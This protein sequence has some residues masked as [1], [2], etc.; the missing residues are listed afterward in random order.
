MRRAL[1]A[2]VLAGAAAVAQ[3]APPAAS[4]VM[5]A[6]GTV[7]RGWDVLDD[8]DRRLPLPERQLIQ[9][10]GLVSGAGSAMMV[11]FSGDCAAQAAFVAHVRRIAAAHGVARVSC[12]ATLP[13]P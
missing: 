6:P 5:L 7:D 10:R 9:A 4:Y 12:A 2:A 8:L 11:R 13:A 3:P 1:V